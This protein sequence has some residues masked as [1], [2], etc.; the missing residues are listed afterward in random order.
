MKCTECDKPALRLDY[1]H[2]HLQRIGASEG[3]DLKL[4][5]RELVICYSVL[6]EI[7]GRRWP[8]TEAQQAKIAL[9]R[10]GITP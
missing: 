4:A 5:N 3:G 8:G 10:L 6:R 7:A 2:E 1:C 9:Q